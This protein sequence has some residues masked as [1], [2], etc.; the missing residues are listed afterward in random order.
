[1]A[2]PGRN[3]RLRDIENILVGH[4]VGKLVLR[5]FDWRRIWGKTFTGLFL[6]ALSA[7]FLGYHN[8]VASWKIWRG[9]RG[10]E[11]V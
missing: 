1:M 7:I 3:A 8:I 10:C 9:R 2:G 6:P 4:M 5:A 11:M